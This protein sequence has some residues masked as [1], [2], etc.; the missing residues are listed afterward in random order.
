MFILNEGDLLIAKTEL[1][2]IQN[3]CQI[4]SD[5]KIVFNWTECSNEHES[6]NELFWLL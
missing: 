5:L 1:L 4:N 6:K 2:N 3:K